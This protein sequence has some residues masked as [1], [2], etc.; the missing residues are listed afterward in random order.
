MEAELPGIEAELPGIEAQRPGIEAERSDIEAERSGVEAQGPGIAAQRPGVAAERSDRATSSPDREIS[1][2]D[3][4][5]K[6]HRPVGS[7]GAR[8]SESPPSV[9][10]RSEA[11]GVH[12]PFQMQNWESGEKTDKAPV[13]FSPLSQTLSPLISFP[14]PEPGL[15]LVPGITRVHPRRAPVAPRR[16]CV[17]VTLTNPN[18][19]SSFNR[20]AVR[21][22]RS[23]LSNSMYPMLEKFV[24]K[25]TPFS[26]KITI[27]SP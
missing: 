11:A 6:L 15:F 9:M 1:P 17:G 13:F 3:G 21:A 10:R 24:G 27:R 12:A 4:S 16:H 22:V 23:P 5:R 2:T 8:G 7:L 25:F 26:L 14:P 18:P 19:I 20:S